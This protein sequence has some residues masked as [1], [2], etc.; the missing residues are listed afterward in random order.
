MKSAV[1][2]CALA[3]LAILRS[4]SDALRLGVNLVHKARDNFFASLSEKTYRPRQC[5]PVQ[6]PLGRL[7]L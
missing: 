5:Q 7:K 3:I 4:P 1:A 2:L 6:T